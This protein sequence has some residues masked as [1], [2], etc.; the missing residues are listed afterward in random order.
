MRELMIGIFLALLCGGYGIWGYGKFA[1]KMARIDSIIIFIITMV[2]C[3]IF[4]RPD[5]LKYSILLG[6]TLV[7]LI[8]SI[9][10]SSLVFI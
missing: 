10:I 3:L 1:K 5:V 8:D 7:A 6:V 9:I 2:V 4:N